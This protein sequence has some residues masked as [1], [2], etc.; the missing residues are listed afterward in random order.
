MRGGRIGRRA[1]ATLGEELSR[2]RLNDGASLRAVGDKAGMSRWTVARY[3]AGDY[4]AATF[5]EMSELLAVLGLGLSVSTY[6]LGDGPRDAEHAAEI[7]GFLAHAAAPLTWRT[8][9][10]LPNAGDARAWDA[11]I[12]GHGKRT[13]VELERRLGD[14]QAIGRRI[15][16]KRRDGGVDHLLVL[17]SDTRRNRAVL[18]ANPAFLADLPRR[19]FKDVLTHLAAGH[20]P[21]DALV[22]I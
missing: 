7:A 16:L 20:H 10:P 8:E 5:V 3:L 17:V 18:R 21:G 14:T 1:L 4:D 19:P 11:V 12:H 6:P 2:A 15:A 13:G 9:V 22:L